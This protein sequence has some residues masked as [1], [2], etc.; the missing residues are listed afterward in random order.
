MLF[1][2]CRCQNIPRSKMCCGP[3]KFHTKTV[4]LSGH[5]PW[6]R[7]CF[8]VSWSL[9]LQPRN[10]QW[11]EG[12]RSHRLWSDQSYRSSP[13]GLHT[14]SWLCLHLRSALMLNRAPKSTSKHLHLD[15]ITSFCVHVRHSASLLYTPN[16]P[17][18][19]HLLSL[20]NHFYLIFQLKQ[21]TFSWSL[22]VHLLNLHSCAVKF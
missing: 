14:K 7:I 5:N 1:W 17:V 11:G 16:L 12:S 22:H 2:H 10:R 3:I 21:L 4:W 8:V 15:G 20:S 9:L 19:P 18:Y 6:V 13:Q